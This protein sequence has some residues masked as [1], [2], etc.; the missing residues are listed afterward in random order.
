ME[1]VLLRRQMP[2]RVAQVDPLR[3]SLSEYLAH[4]RLIVHSHSRSGAWN[5]A[6]GDFRGDWG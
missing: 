6:C 2:L 1:R 5:D 4:V 3:D